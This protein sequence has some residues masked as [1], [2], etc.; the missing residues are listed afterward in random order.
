MGKCTHKYRI[1]PNLL[2]LKILGILFKI[3]FIECIFQVKV[4][5]I[6]E[7]LFA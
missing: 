6:Y 7:I 4:S 1:M 2:I 3:Q 5:I